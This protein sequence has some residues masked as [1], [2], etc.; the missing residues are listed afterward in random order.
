DERPAIRVAQQV[1]PRRH[2][3][4]VRA[5]RDG[6]EQIFVGRQLAAG[7]GA[8]LEL[9]R[10]EIARWRHEERRAVAV[11]LAFGAVTLRAVRVVELFASSQTPLPRPPTPGHRRV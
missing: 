5:A 6:A 2:A 9:S 11:A 10:R 3:G 1:L 8:E 4:A 7:G